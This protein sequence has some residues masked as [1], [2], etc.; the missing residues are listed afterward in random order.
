MTCH[1]LSPMKLLPL[2]SAA[3]TV[4]LA[5]I[6]PAAEKSLQQIA[7]EQFAFAAQ[8]YAG[9]LKRMEAEPPLHQPRSF[10]G[11]KLKAV[12]PEDWTSGFFPGSLWLVYEHTGDTGLKTAAD[13]YTRRLDRLKTYGGTHDLGFMIGCSYGQA[14]R[15]TGDAS[16]LQVIREGAKTLATRFNSKAGVIRSWDFGP[17]TFPVIV[18]N[19]MNLEFLVLASR[20][21]G[22]AH[23]NEIALTHANTTLKNH[24]REDGSSVHLVDYNPETGSVVKKQT[25]QGFA[26]PSSWARGQA[27]GLYG[28]TRMAGLTGEARYLEQARRIADFIVN[29]PRLP[30]DGIPFWDYDVPHQPDALRDASAG[31]ITACALLELA[32]LVDGAEAERYRALGEKQLR[33]LSTGF[34]RA[35]LN[36]NGN[37]LIM[38][39]VGHLPDK[40]EVDVPLAYA[41]YYFLEGLARYATKRVKAANR[42]FAPTSR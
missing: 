28:Y 30:A 25:V 39:C 15:M 10:V 42:D 19:M 4:T 40:S 16:Y 17:W 8:Q 32:D 9:L 35:D 6:A 23:L 27:W 11:G 3:L 22:E 21:G 1:P 33:S 36:E 5:A 2:V 31:A 24:F 18:D 37:F 13:A 7:D 12:R 41:D 20:R 14:Y 26:D 29:H 38:H 34:Y